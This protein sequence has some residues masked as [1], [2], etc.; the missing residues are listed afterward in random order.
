MTTNDSAARPECLEG[1]HHVPMSDD[2]GVTCR[3]CRTP[4]RSG[5]V[6]PAEDSAPPWVRE[7]GYFIADERATDGT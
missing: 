1:G 4:M 2:D 3:Y 6:V 7:T 5:R